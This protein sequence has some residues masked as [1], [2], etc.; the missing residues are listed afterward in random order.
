MGDLRYMDAGGRFWR[1][2]VEGVDSSVVGLNVVARGELL[3][4]GWFE[5]GW[6]GCSWLEGGWF[7]GGWLDNL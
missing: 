6:F 1:R 2:R 4:G 3:V 7:V 5:D